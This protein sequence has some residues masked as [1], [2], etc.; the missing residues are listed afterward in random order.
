MFPESDIA[1]QFTCGERKAAY[2]TTFG[3]APQ[4]SSLMKAKAKKESEYVLVFDESLNREIKKSQLDMHIRF[5]DG[6][7]VNSRYLTSFFMGHHTANQ[8]H[9]K[10][11]KPDSAVDGW[12]KCEFE[13][14]LT[15]PAEH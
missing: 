8:M 13:A 14:L 9:E 1:K 4:F 2:L 5:W 10:V 6:N 7:Q 3:I 15:G 11:E 12:P